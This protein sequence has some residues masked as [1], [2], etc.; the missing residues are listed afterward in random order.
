MHSGHLLSILCIPLGIFILIKHKFWKYNSYETLF[1]TG[2]R[3]F[4]SGLIF[5]MIGVF[6]IYDIVVKLFK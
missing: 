1:W 2:A 5:L 6:G 4:I 3:N